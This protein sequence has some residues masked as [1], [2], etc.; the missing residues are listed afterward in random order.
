MTQISF[1][2]PD[3]VL[4]YQQDYQT[5]LSIEDQMQFV[6]EASRLNIHH[7]TGGPFAAAVIEIDTG[8]LLSLGVNLV[9]SE[10]LSV[11][12]AEIV[13][14]SIAQ[15][16]KGTYDLGA[17][18][19]LGYALLSSTEP[20][21]MCLGAIPWSGI[22]RLITAATDQD[23]RAIGFDEGCKPPGGLRSLEERGIKVITGVLRAE[24][25]AV[26]Q[27]YQ[28]HGGPIYNSREGEPC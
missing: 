28:Q 15:R 27:A 14:I 26:L 11:L 4:A 10:G 17:S 22:R 9:T 2:L 18:D 12:H 8:R 1:S 19:Q 20:C 6:I 5:S 23:A 21:A 13:A 3:W 25:A 7:Q 24:A 16:A